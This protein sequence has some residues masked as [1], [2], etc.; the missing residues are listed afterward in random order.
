MEFRKFGDNTYF[1]RLDIG[2]EVVDSLKNL[3]RE[4]GIK[5]G[6]IQGFGTCTRAQIGSLDTTTLE[7]H[8]R[9]YSGDMEIT[10]LLGTITQMNGD[11]YLHVHATFALPDN[12]VIG[13]H[14]DFAEVSAVAEIFIQSFD[15]EVDREYSE[16][17]GVNLLKFT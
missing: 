14:L 4:N 11:T 8:P 5:L 17:A 1:V 3:C 16:S 13:G 12:S 7:Y 9:I 2:D 6:S 10:S 15:G